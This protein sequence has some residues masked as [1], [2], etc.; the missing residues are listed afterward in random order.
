MI[1]NYH[2]YI[3]ATIDRIVADFFWERE[4]FA[5]FQARGSVHRYRFS[6]FTLFRARGDGHRYRFSGFTLFRARGS[7]HRYRFSGF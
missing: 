1:N 4:V 6:G 2:A 5:L 3:T 7:V